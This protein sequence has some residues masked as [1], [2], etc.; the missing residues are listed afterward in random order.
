MGEGAQ[1]HDY[2]VYG[3]ENQRSLDLRPF[4]LGKQVATSL[5]DMY[6][7]F[8]GQP[9]L[10]RSIRFAVEKYADQLAQPDKI[11]MYL[12]SFLTFLTE[13]DAHD[14]DLHYIDRDVLNA[15]A[16]WLTR[17]GLGQGGRQQQHSTGN[18]I[19]RILYSSLTEHAPGQ[20]P[21]LGNFGTKTAIAYPKVQGT[22][23]AQTIDSS[24]HLSPKMLEKVGAYCLSVLDEIDNEN[25][26][27]N[28][29][30][31][32]GVDKCDKRHVLF[33]YLQYRSESYL[34]EKTGGKWLEK[35]AN[36]FPWKTK[37]Y[38]FGRSSGPLACGGNASEMHIALFPSME[39]MLA[40]LCLVAIET[41]FTEGA[42][43]IGLNS[44]IP[45]AKRPGCPASSELV[46]ILPG[47]FGARPKTGRS[48]KSR[49]VTTCKGGA[50]WALR[51]YLKRSKRLRDMGEQRLKIMKR[52]LATRKGSKTIS[53]KSL[54]SD[55]ATLNV[56]LHQ[57]LIY[58][59]AQRGRLISAQDVGRSNV[60]EFM[61]KALPETNNSFYDLRHAYAQK[62]LQETGSVFEVQAALGHVN[63]MTTMEYLRSRNM[64]ED[65]FEAVTRVAGIVYDE[66]AKAY[67]INIDIVRARFKLGGRDLTDKERAIFPV[68]KVGARCTDSKNPP[69]LMDPKN[70][71]KG[72]TGCTSG[73]C[74][75]CPSSLWNN[76]EIGFDFLAADEIARLRRDIRIQRHA[77]K[78]I[79]LEYQLEAWSAL[80]GQMPEDQQTRIDELANL[81]AHNG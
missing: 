79:W 15:H 69:D 41:G 66:I 10:L 60:A 38:A 77:E 2:L 11:G 48:Y 30:P 52:D 16:H 58:M 49:A 27:V 81:D 36:Q 34:D 64:R 7:P 32:W 65:A 25:T 35:R 9:R 13:I 54:E 76:K 22:R 17:R 31:E 23:A 8:V 56:S 46:Q 12:S 42:K 14:V 45:S 29:V 28:V 40:S 71:A 68:T 37:P 57:V 19:F 39:E 4:Y 61:A 72:P 6:C 67:E 3:R 20:F 73:N 78:R 1:V 74:I 53:A 80:L 21:N 33:D 63:T 59:T 62:I 43:Q 44:I 26:F 5:N 47:Q 55:I 18:Q 50:Y 70:T 51:R 75:L 24:K